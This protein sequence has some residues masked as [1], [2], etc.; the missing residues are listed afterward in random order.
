MNANRW[1]QAGVAIAAVAMAGCS[2]PS[3]AVMKELAELR[4]RVQRQEDIEAV[5][6][7]AFSYGYYMDNAL[8]D[9]VTALF[10]DRMEY[11]EIAGYG[12]Y[13][14]RQGCEKIWKEILGPSLQ[15]E[16]GRLKFGRLIKHY[17]VK[18]IVTVA[19]DGATAEGRFDYIGFSGVFGEP[20]RNSQ[21]LGVYRMGFVREEGVWKIARFNLSFDTSD[22]SDREWTT[23]TKIRCPRPGAPAPDDAF[24]L[25]HPFPEHA[26]VPFFEP[27]P[28]SGER[29]PDYVNPRRY[30]Q[31]NWP[32]EMGGPCG[33]APQGDR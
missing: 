5:R 14:G 9:Q 6:R 33:V 19:A 21:Q 23:Q 3:D 26:T 8:M 7:V 4:T 22:W 11:C 12:L 13:R 25:H 28:V 17:L 20:R 16:D 32:G 30:W 24:L 2:G 10:A 27:N 18:D 15:N 29:V 31:G 1:V